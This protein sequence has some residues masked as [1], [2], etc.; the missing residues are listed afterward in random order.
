MIMASQNKI[1]ALSSP[2][3]ERN[4]GAILDQLERLLPAKG[5]VLEIAS[6]TGQHVVHFAAA[7]PILQWQPTEIHADSLVSVHTRREAAGLDN[8]AEPVTL[9][10]LEHPWPVERADAIVCINMI[11]IAPWAAAEGLFRGAQRILAPGARLILYGPYRWN[12]RHTAPSNEAFDASLR[13]R[14]PEWGVRE[15]EDVE[16]LAVRYDFAP[17][18]TVAMPANNLIVAFERR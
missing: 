7:L 17:L 2:A 8:I 16:A 14:D 6:G 10:V 12:G 5:L 11:H 13:A 3:A 4:K 18:E 15:L 9:D 1:G